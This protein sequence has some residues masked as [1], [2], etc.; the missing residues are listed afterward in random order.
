MWLLN[1]VQKLISI[2][3]TGRKIMCKHYAGKSKWKSVQEI[4]E[5]KSD[6]K[7][8]RVRVSSRKSTARGRGGARREWQIHRECD[9]N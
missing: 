9:P 2:E 6:A 3:Y 4:E 7:P 1:F 8:K 5:K